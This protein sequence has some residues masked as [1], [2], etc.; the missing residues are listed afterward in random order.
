MERGELEQLSDG[1]LLAVVQGDDVANAERAFEVMYFRHRDFVFRVARRFARDDELAMDAAQEVFAYLLKKLPRLR[2]TGKLS[3]YLYPIA[4]NAGVDRRRK[5]KGDR[6]KWEEKARVAGE[7]MVGEGVGEASPEVVR[8]MEELPE[9]QREVLLMRVV[10]GMSVE[11]VARA[12]GVP[13]GTVKSRLFHAIGAMR[14][15]LGDIG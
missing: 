11:E 2:L 4:R 10:D 8:A 9:A 6:R 3:T 12:L 15:R 1:E 13:E 5:A 7:A 14:E